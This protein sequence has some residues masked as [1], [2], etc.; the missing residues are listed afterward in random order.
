MQYTNITMAED[1]GPPG[2]AHLRAVAAAEAGSPGNPADF[3]DALLVALD[4]FVKTIT[5]RPELASK[6]HKRIVL[7]R[8]GA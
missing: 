1:M 7:V 8:R 3:F 5:E 4:M 2:E 6:V